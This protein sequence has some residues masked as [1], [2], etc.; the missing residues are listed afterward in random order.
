MKRDI[1]CGEKIR[2]AAI[3][4]DQMVGLFTQAF[5]DSEFSRLLDTSPAQIYSSKAHRKFI[6]D[7]LMA[8]KPDLF[9]FL[10]RTLE[11][12]Y[13]I[14]EVD[15]HV[16]QWPNGDAFVGIGIVNGYQGQGYGTDAMRV[17]LRYA[18]TEINLRRV[19]LN[20]FEYNPCAI[21]SYEKAGFKPEGRM[22]G[23][24][25]REGRRHDLIYM[26]ILREEWMEN[27]TDDRD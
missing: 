2:L 14:G 16:T 27:H 20:V 21:R 7:E 6:E 4:T 26:G 9:S 3:D 12:D 24:L 1:F 13:L 23:F 15:L 10:I 19:T 17:I 11:G 25:N 8:D 5:R 22:R 18:F